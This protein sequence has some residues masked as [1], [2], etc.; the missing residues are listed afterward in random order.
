MSKLF[1][2]ENLRRVPT[3]YRPVAFWFL[4]HFLREDELRRQ[5]REMAGKGFGGIMLHARDGLRSGY[6]NGEW[7]KALTWCLD[8]AQKHGMDA[9]LYDELNYPT[10]PA[11]GR[12]FDY[13]PDSR[14]KGLELIRR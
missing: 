9:W 13:L 3:A 2:L 10:G 14:M 11:G 8:E 6:L 5:V 4:N 12:M 7:K 1:F